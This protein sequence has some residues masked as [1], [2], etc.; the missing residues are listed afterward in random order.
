MVQRDGFEEDAHDARRFRRGDAGVQHRRGVV[1]PRG[2][3]DHHAWDVADRGDGVVVVEVAAESF[4]VSVSGHP[5]HHRIAVL[6]IREELQRRAFT[7]NLVRG[8]VEIGEVLD[9]GDRQQPRDPGAER[10]AQDRLLVEQ[11]VEDPRRTRLGEQSPGHS[12]HTALAGDVFTEDH[13]LGMAVQDVLQR[14]VDR[15]CHRHRR[16]GLTGPDRCDK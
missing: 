14:M 6:P 9:L 4:L 12:V 10:K 13:R 7:A 3:G 15:Q 11:R 1:G 5:H 16:I 8:V 2:R